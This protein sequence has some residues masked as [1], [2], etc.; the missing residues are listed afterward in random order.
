M[1]QA[2]RKKLSSI[3]QGSIPVF[4]IMKPRE[5]F[6]IV[7]I[8]IIESLLKI[9]IDRNLSNFYRLDRLECMHKK[10]DEVEKSYEGFIPEEYKNRHEKFIKFLYTDLNS[11]LKD[12]KTIKR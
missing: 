6:D 2:R 3:D 9:L 12:I 7:L 5:I 10:M 11:L 1:G 4:F 8:S